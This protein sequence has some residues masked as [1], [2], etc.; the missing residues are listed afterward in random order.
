MLRD[1]LSN[2]MVIQRFCLPVTLHCNLR[3]R[4]CAER[5]PYY[6]RP[7]YPEMSNLVAQIGRLFEIVDRIELLDLTGGEP[8]LRKDLHIFIR[9]LYRSYD[10]RIGRLRLTTNGTI[11]PTEELLA[12]LQDWGNRV[13]LIVD[14]YPVSKRVPDIA[15]HLSGAGV[16]FEVRD[17]TNSLHCDGWVDYGDFSKKHDAPEAQALFKKCMVPRLHF[18]TCM[19][20]GVLFPCARAR[21]L[22]EQGI[23]KDC[24]NIMDGPCSDIREKL[25]QFLSVSALESCAYCGGLCEDSK[26][27]RPAE[28]LDTLIGNKEL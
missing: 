6:E 11:L 22:Y 27:F 10:Q 5:S 24:L 17:Y 26:R 9:E 16:P 8:L 15:K 25:R 19:V 14:Q 1:E 2:S 28:Q 7:Y 13:Y 21:L 3:C 23:T 18:F 4:L 20:D 12:S